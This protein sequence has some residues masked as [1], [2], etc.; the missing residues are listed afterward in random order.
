MLLSM[1]IA[2]LTA[3]ERSERPKP[4]VLG[5]LRV[6]VPFRRGTAP[7][8]SE[9]QDEEITKVI[10]GACQLLGRPE[11]THVAKLGAW[12]YEHAVRGLGQT[13]IRAPER[14]STLQA[15]AHL[16]LELLEADLCR[17]A[18][19]DVEMHRWK[20]G[21]LSGRWWEGSRLEMD[22]DDT[23]GRSAT[24]RAAKD[25]RPVIIADV[26]EVGK[27][28]PPNTWVRGCVALPLVWEGARCDTV[29][30]LWHHV[31][32]WFSQF[33]PSLLESLVAIGGSR[34]QRVRAID[35]QT[36]EEQRHTIQTVSHELAHTMKN[37][38]PEEPFVRLLQRVPE[39]LKPLATE[40]LTKVKKIGSMRRRFYHLA[41]MDAFRSDGPH[42]AGELYAEL[43]VHLEEIAALFG[44]PIKSC[45]FEDFD[46][47]ILCSKHFLKD[48]VLE[49]LHNTDAHGR[50]QGGPPPEV[51]FTLR[52][53]NPDDLARSSVLSDLEGNR[54]YAA[55]EYADSGPG[56]LKEKK[57]KIFVAK[58]GQRHLG[59]ET[60]SMGLGLPLARTL[61]R[62][63]G[64]DMIESGTPGAGARFVIMFKTIA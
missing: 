6:Q 16:M 37:L 50:R 42:P 24:V 31:M 47:L 46:Q 34:V 40:C 36:A 28:V 39:P 15:L 55:I 56:I 10:E 1:F 17:V 35:L 20:S 32:D 19:H 25:G 38:L 30:T 43:K 5:L 18:V 52:I 27:S 61:A 2:E 59:A 48:D 11:A 58:L 51:S 41:E 29:I 4:K 44:L 64:G 63:L 7:G 21:P 23:D 54:P 9:E 22:I 33:D 57:E 14:E 26:Q 45:A 62:K 3:G 8:M 60:E 13:P 49:L 12:Q 53:A